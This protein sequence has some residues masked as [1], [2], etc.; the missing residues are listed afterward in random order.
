MKIELRN[1]TAGSGGGGGGAVWGRPGGHAPSP[2]ARPGSSRPRHRAR[3]AA[4]NPVSPGIAFFFSSR[5]KAECRASLSSP[6]LEAMA[7]RC[8]GGPLPARAG[9]A[10][11]PAP[12]P[13][14]PQPRPAR[15]ARRAGTGRVPAGLRLGLP[16]P[17]CPPP[18]RPPGQAAVAVVPPPPSSTSTASWTGSPL[19]PHTW[20]CGTAH[21]PRL[22]PSGGASRTTPRVGGPSPSRL[23]QADLAFR[24]PPLH[25]Q[26]DHG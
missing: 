13:A 17:P 11:R 20:S 14:R 2:H 18:G 15:P 24:H 21:P 22:A 16:P 12:R 6:P 1:L 9:R 8:G 25:H 4:G 3:W 10:L 23:A 7:S 5:R 26:G 19:Q